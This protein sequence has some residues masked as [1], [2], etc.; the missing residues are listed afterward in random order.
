MVISA[1]LTAIYSFRL[2]EQVFWS[3]YSGF[4]AVILNHTKVTNLETMVLGILAA[5]S[6]STGYFCKDSFIGAGSNYFNQFI[7]VLPAT[8]YLIEAEFLGAE[9]K[10]TPFMLGNLAFEADSRFLECKWFYNEFVNGFVILPALTAS[11]HIFE[12]YEKILLEQNGP[13]FVGALVNSIALSYLRGKK[14]S[15][16]QQR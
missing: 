2:L 5:L 11:R 7:H 9:I 12:Q 8:N 1:I 4:K 6:L 16:P 3:D 14:I 10:L 13:L 15:L